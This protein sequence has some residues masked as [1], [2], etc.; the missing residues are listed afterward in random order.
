MLRLTLA[1]PLAL[2]PHFCFH[3]SL[4]GASVM[5]RVLWILSNYATSSCQP[6]CPPPTPLHP[7]STKDE[8]IPPGVSYPDTSLNYLDLEGG[9]LSAHE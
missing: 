5:S 1:H 2:C 6:Q 8:G 9:T 3:S 4:P 7:L